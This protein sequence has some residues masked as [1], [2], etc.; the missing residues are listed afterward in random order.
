[1]L[2]QSLVHLGIVCLLCISLMFI[3]PETLKISK[4]QISFSRKTKNLS[5]KLNLESFLR[6]MTQ[7]DDCLHTL[8]QGLNTCRLTVTPDR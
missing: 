2:L 1:M 6:V 3:T 5:K 7:P 8:W 4:A